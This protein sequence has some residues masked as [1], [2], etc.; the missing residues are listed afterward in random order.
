MVNIQGSDSGISLSSQETSGHSSGGGGGHS[1]GLD[2]GAPP[3]ARPRPRLP[4]V[5]QVYLA[6]GGGGVAANCEFHFTRPASAPAPA[7]PRPA[8]SVPSLD[9]KSRLQAGAGPPSRPGSHSVPDAGPGLALGLGPGRGH[10]VPSI[11]IGPGPGIGLYHGPPPDPGPGSSLDLGFTIGPGPGSD[12]SL[13]LPFSMP[14]LAR[15]LTSGPGRP[16]S[17]GRPPPLVLNLAGPGPA[18]S[19][20]PALPLD[21]QV[22]DGI[23]LSSFTISLIGRNELF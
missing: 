2:K 4:Q 1:S 11:P 10:H 8:S 17:L 19:L 18:P 16:G 9:I 21:S 3:P 12:P 22:C 13:D 20:D 6:G 5:S 23:V 15:R 7:P 14:K